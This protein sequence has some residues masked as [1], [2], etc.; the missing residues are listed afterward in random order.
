MSLFSVLD[1]AVSGLHA[2]EIAVNITSNNIANVDTE[3]YSRQRV[4]LVSE[5]PVM[6]SGVV[7]GRGVR[8]GS[9]VRARDELLD[10]IYRHQASTLAGSTS[11]MPP[12]SSGGWPSGPV[13]PGMRGS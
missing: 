13:P 8:V 11:R 1:I 9:I 5:E 3:G 2:H 10:V 7:I 4:D 6:V 12:P